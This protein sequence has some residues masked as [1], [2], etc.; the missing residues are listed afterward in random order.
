M[1]RIRPADRF[2][3]KN[4]GFEYQFLSR[5]IGRRASPLQKM[6]RSAEMGSAVLAQAEPVQAVS[7]S[8]IISCALEAGRRASAAWTAK[9]VG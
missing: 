8:G 4:G 3:V 6:A 5:V 1:V 9:E 7:V 2:N